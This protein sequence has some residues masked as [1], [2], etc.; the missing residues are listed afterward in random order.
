MR[1]RLQR[2][3]VFRAPRCSLPVAFGDLGLVG[4]TLKE[5]GG[6]VKPE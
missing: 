3:Q 4:L 1:A 6:V 2:Q 5:G